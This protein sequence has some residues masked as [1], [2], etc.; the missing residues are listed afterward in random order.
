MSVVRRPFASPPEGLADML[1]PVPTAPQSRAPGSFGPPSY[2]PPS[3]G[4][5]S[6]AGPFGSVHVSPPPL[7]PQDMAFADTVVL[8]GSLEEPIP[9]SG[10]A[11]VT[12]PHM[13]RPFGPACTAGVESS[14]GI[15]ER[16]V[17]AFR[18]ARDEMRDLWAGTGEALGPV[19][20]TLPPVIGFARRM[21]VLWSFWEWDRKDLVRAGAI[22][23]AVFFTV[24][25]VVAVGL[26]RSHA[27]VSPEPTRVA[28]P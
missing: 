13:M 9:P 2:G 23:L 15:G 20:P 14:S 25:A 12:N 10:P 5:P 6:Y 17:A 24:I 8:K 3:Y 4:P 19:P 16:T 28:S 1:E 11:I 21:R 26:A 22:G 27:G 18:S 7:P